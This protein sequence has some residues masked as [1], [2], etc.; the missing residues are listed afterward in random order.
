MGKATTHQKFPRSSLIAHAREPEI[1]TLVLHP[2]DRAPVSARR[3][4]AERFHE[5]GHQDDYVGRVVVTELVTNAY[6]HGAGFIVVRVFR[7]ERD[8]LAVIE[9]WDHG[10][11]L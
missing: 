9:V 8:G 5:W 3:F 4:V 1:P 2:T 10:P 11:G 7:D 6:Q